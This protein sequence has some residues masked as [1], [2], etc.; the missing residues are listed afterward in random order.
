M[1]EKIKDI[2][3][4]IIKWDIQFS[5]R[6]FLSESRIYQRRIASFF[7]HSGDSWFLLAGLF[8]IWILSKGLTHTYSALFAGAIVIQAS[9]IIGL[10]YLIKR[11]RPEGNWGSIYR[12]T[13]PNSF[14]SGHAVR[15]VM[16][17][18]MSW[19]LGIFPLNWILTIWAPLV[20]FARVMLGVHFLI[21]IIAGWIL[22]ILLAITILT[23]QP[24]FI[25]LFPFIF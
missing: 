25:Q 19:G 10:K 6:F 3:K 16:L 8:I 4:E 21:D 13:D 18:A 15:V 23:L 2:F 24:F 12:N 14:P 9:F 11:S 17:A 5:E 1:L 20:S 7:A 22:G